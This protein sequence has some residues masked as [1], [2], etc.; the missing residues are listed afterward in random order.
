MDDRREQ[1]RRRESQLV[2]RRTRL[3]ER[4]GL[5]VAEP[6]RLAHK[7]RRC[8]R[9]CIYCRSEA[10]RRSVLRTE[11]ALALDDDDREALGA[12]AADRLGRLRT[13]RRHQ[14]VP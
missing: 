13:R 11:R 5:A 6:H 12:H 7:L 2:E 4:Y 1:R 9:G 8:G 10:D 14:Q 3:L